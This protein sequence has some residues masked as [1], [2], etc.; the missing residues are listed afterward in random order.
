MSFL[1]TSDSTSLRRTSSLQLTRRND[2]RVQMRKKKSLV[3]RTKRQ[4][5]ARRRKMR[6]TRKRQSRCLSGYVTLSSISRLSHMIQVHCHLMRVPTAACTRRT[7]WCD[8]RTRGAENGSATGE[9]LARE[10][11]S[12]QVLQ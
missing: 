2:A 7:Q 3:K 8:A 1:L 9:A 6:K 10:R 5:R 4:R 11:N 12:Q